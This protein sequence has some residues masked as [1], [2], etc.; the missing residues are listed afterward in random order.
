MFSFLKKAVDPWRIVNSEEEN[1]KFTEQ[2]QATADHT[3]NPWIVYQ[4]I[5]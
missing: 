3:L 4:A 2:V 1:A 5:L